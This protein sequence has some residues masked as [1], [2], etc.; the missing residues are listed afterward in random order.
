MVV[1]LFILF[2]TEDMSLCLSYCLAT[3]LLNLK[4]TIA[5]DDVCLFLF[6]VATDVDAL[7]DRSSRGIGTQ[8]K[9]LLRLLVIMCNRVGEM[10]FDK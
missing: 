9:R 10:S 8:L 3:K 7:N 4:S 2:Y 6:V 5:T 1:A